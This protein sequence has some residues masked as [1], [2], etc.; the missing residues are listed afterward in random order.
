MCGAH[1]WAAFNLNQRYF[2]ES[3]CIN[4]ECRYYRD[5]SL[6]IQ[7]AGFPGTRFSGNA[8][9]YV[10]NPWYT[11]ANA[12]IEGFSMQAISSF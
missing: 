11:A 9:V 12:Y 7:C 4:N 1:Y 8:W 10:S 5:G 2:Y 3:K 6:L